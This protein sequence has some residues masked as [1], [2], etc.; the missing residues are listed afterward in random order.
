[1]ERAEKLQVY[2]HLPGAGETAACST[3]TPPGLYRP[4]AD[5]YL[6]NTHTNYISVWAISTPTSTTST[7][8]TQEEQ[9]QEEEEED[10]D[11]SVLMTQGQLPL[12]CAPRAL[13]SGPCVFLYSQGSIFPGSCAFSDLFPGFYFQSSMF[14]QAYDSVVLRLSCSQGSMF[15]NSIVPKVLS[16]NAPIVLCSS[17]L[18]Y[19]LM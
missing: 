1:M 16:S 12:F 9:E 6:C 5:H 3:S 4:T 15:P 7:L 14:T 2:T 11:S 18:I 8:L 19:M 13:F 17:G 10:D